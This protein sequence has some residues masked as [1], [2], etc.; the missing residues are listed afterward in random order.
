M[1]HALSLVLLPALLAGCAALQ[2]ASPPTAETGPEPA[3][4]RPAARPPE[5]APRTAEAFDTTTVEERTAAAAA[6]AAP[7]ELRLGTTVASLGDPTEAGFWLKTP[8]VDAPAAGRVVF[9]GT[10]KS[11]QV[12]LRPRDAEPGAG[13]QISLSAMRLIGA[14]LTGLPE[15]EVYRSPGA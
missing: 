11:A 15:I 13:S 5:G 10:G 3:A 4:V 1:K 8:L 12:E 7:R 6:P 2:P 14:P 9:P